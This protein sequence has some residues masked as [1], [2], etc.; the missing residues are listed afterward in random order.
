MEPIEIGA[1]S[2]IQDGV[3]IHFRSG[4]AVTIGKRTSI[5]HRA[6]VHGPCT[7]GDDVFIGFN[8]ALFTCTVVKGCVITRRWM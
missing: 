8:N 1:H 5:V 3:V 7:M 2:N 6:I 4:A